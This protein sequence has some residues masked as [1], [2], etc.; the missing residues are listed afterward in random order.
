MGKG[1]SKRGKEMEVKVLKEE[2]N[3][4]VFEIIGEDHTFCNVLRHTLSTHK[5]VL[6]ASYRIEHPL[7]SNPKMYIKTKDIPLPKGKER[8]L[9]LTE[10]KGVGPKVEERLRGA[11]I[12]TAN[13]LLKADLEKVSKKSGI[14]VKVLE[15]YAEEARKL[16]FAKE[17]FAR[18]ILKDALKDLGKVFAGVR[19]D[20]RG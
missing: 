19:A 10:I 5:D 1:R 2:K 8:L 6:F 17:S 12:K 14:S 4:M 13:A 3:E 16:D 7:L 15:K 11:G 18:I 20:V 9:P